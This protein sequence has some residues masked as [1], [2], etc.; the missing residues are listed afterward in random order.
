MSSACSPV[1]LSPFGSVY[2]LFLTCWLFVSVPGLFSG[3]GEWYAE[4]GLQARGFRS[5]AQGLSSLAAYGIFLDQRSKPCPLALA[6]GVLTTGPPGRSLSGSLNKNLST[7]RNG[8]CPHFRSNRHEHSQHLLNITLITE[9]FDA[10]TH[11]ILTP[12]L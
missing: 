5:W 12:E 3:C 7:A 4:H 6:D 1:Q 10:L 11:F 2:V 9:S 8:S